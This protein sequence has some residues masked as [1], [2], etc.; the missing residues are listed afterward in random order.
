MDSSDLIT[1]VHG[2]KVGMEEFL[3]MPGWSRCRERGCLQER[4]AGS[5]GGRSDVPKKRSLPQAAEHSATTAKNRTFSVLS[6]GSSSSLFLFGNRP[7][8]EAKKVPRSTSPPQPSTLFL[9]PRRLGCPV[10][11]L[12][13]SQGAAAM[14]SNFEFWALI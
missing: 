3:A 2:M 13:L 10:A 1:R 4:L 12:A 8:K 7:S 9:C 6:H 5:E 14:C 11:F